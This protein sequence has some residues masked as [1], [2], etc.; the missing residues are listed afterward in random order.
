[1]RLPEYD[2]LDALGLAALVARREV[3]AAELLEAALERLDAR[4]PALNAVVARYDEEARA[5]AAGR[6]EGPFA[7]VPFVLKDLFTAW[8]GHPMTFGSRLGQGYVPDYDAEVVRRLE[9]AGL[10]LF[11][12]TNAPELGILAHTEPVLHGPARNPWSPDHT[13]GGSSGGSAAAV[14]ARIVPAAHGNDGGGSIRIPASHCGLFGLKPTRGRVSMAPAFGEAWLGFAS[15]GVLTR[16]VRDSAALLD[17]L[18]GPMPGDPYA[19][20]PHAGRFADEVGA[21]P[22]RLRVAFTDRSFFGHGTGPD[23]VAAVRG[24]AALLEELG[25]DVEEARPPFDRG[26]MVLAYLYVVAAGVAASVTEIAKLTGRKPGRATLEPETLALAAAGHAVSAAE[27]AAALEAMR[28]MGREFGRFF[29]RYDLLVTPTVAEPPPRVGALQPSAVERL[30]LR[31]AAAS[32]SRRLLDLLF[33]Q[34]G[35]RSFDATG[36]TMPFN[37]TGQPAMSVPLHQTAAGLPMG[38][39]VVGR[40]GDEATLLRVAAQL[41]AARP[42]AG[43]APRGVEV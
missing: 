34:V 12:L 28:R 4:N 37:Q 39:Q 9:G 38:V 18:A 17:V 20:P 10:V 23:A 31:V 3:T 27:L 22:G 32:R 43:R 40:F 15:E 1:M 14:A 21:P 2:R 33:A 19:A 25:H 35:D 5:R 7:G 16:S 36:F 42:W 30:G 13:P 26:P 24:A 8:K 41:E 6:L 11:G 29:E